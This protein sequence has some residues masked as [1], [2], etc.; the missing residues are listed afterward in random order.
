MAASLTSIK[1]S[2][3]TPSCPFTYSGQSVSTFVCHASQKQV[4]ETE[5]ES[6][7]DEA[8]GLFT[9]SNQA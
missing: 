5:T 8:K 3:A 1:I 4:H 2:L 6:F 7:N 9:Q